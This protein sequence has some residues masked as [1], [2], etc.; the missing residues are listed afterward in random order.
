MLDS[1]TRTVSLKISRLPAYQHVLQILQTH[2]DAV[3]LDIGCC[4]P[5][6]ALMTFRVLIGVF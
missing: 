5:Y 4:C 3:L 1:F 2:P 6:F